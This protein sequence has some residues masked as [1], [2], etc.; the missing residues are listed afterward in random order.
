MI[1]NWILFCCPKGS[2]VLY[3][4][5]YEKENKCLQNLPEG[6]IVPGKWEDYNDYE[7]ENDNPKVHKTEI[8]FEKGQKKDPDLIKLPNRKEIAKK[9]YEQKMA[10]DDKEYEKHKD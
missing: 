6:K 3:Y 7:D 1:T 2:K 10:Q 4:K 8:K 9:A 5:A